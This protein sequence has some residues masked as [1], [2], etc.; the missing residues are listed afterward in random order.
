MSAEVEARMSGLDLKKKTD[1]AQAEEDDD[2]AMLS[3]IQNDDD[4]VCGLGEE[5]LHGDSR[6]KDKGRPLSVD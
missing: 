3:L 6:L 2:A 5:C 4:F 1:E